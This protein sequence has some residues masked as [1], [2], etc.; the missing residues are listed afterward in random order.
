MPQYVIDTLKPKNNNNFP[1]AEAV[2]V[3]YEEGSTV[4]DKI[5]AINALIVA[6]QQLIE[7][8]QTDISELQSSKVDKVS[9]KDLSTNDFTNAYR[10]KIDD[11]YTKSETDTALAGKVD[12]VSGKGL[13]TNDFTNTYKNK[14]DNTYTKTETDSAI[15][16]KIAEVVAEAP[17]SFDTLKEIADWIDT[18][19]DSASAMNSAIQA[20]AANIEKKVDKVSGKDLSTNDFT[21]AYKDKIDDTYSKS[22]VDNKMK[23]KVDK[24]EG[25]DLSTNDF[26]NDYQ[27]RIHDTYT[28]AVTNA[29]AIEQLES[30]KADKSALDETN[31]AV[32]ANKENLQ[33]QID[34]LVLNAGGDSSPEVTQARVGLDGTSYETLKSRLDAEREAEQ[35]DWSVFKK[36]ISADKEIITH[37]FTTEGSKGFETSYK[38][39]KGVKYEIRVIESQNEELSAYIKDNIDDVVR[40]NRKAS[41][42][43]VPQHTGCLAVYDPGATVGSLV[44]VSIRPMIYDIAVE[45]VITQAKYADYTIDGYINN[46][47]TLSSETG[48]RTDYIPIKFGT[49]ISGYAR[50]LNGDLGI[51][52]FFDADKKP[53]SI[54]YGTNEYENYEAT[55]PENAA[56]VMFSK[57]ATFTETYAVVEWDAINYADKKTEMLE[58]V[59]SHTKAIKLWNFTIDGYVN[60][61][62][63]ISDETGKRT[64]YIPVKCGA[65]ITG[66]ARGLNGNLGIYGFFDADKNP[67]SAYYGTNDYEDYNVIVP[68]GVAYV[69]FSTFTAYTD[70]RAEIRWDALKYADKKVDELK[71]EVGI[72]RT[73]R[74][75]FGSDDGE[76]NF[77]NLYA[78]FEKAAKTNG[79]KT[80]H[81]NSGTYDLLS[82]MGGIEYISSKEN[83]KLSF[84]EVQPVMTDITIKGWGR[85]VIN[86]LLPERTVTDVPQLFSAINVKGNSHIENV[87]IHSCNCRY[88]IHDESG[89]KYPNTTS[90]YKNVKCYHNENGETLG[91]AQAIGCGYS[92]H[93]KVNLEDCYLLSNGEVWSCHANDG[94]EINFKNCVFKSLSSKDKALRISQNGQKNINAYIDSCYISNGLSLRNEWTE[95]SVTDVTNVVLI[96]TKINEVRNG[97][98]TVIEPVI[99]YNTVEGTETVL[100]APTD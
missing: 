71:D 63:G 54:F 91:Q 64:D 85:V 98:T 12:K 82:E 17:E 1:V 83:Q 35:E 23:D 14:V 87:E 92:D 9:G 10:D 4:K 100:L 74:V 34:N 65:V 57:I 50:G 76:H 5:I 60:N 26:T 29:S 68:S 22:E 72:E 81:I 47:G 32:A 20:N 43:F 28:K 96:N 99:S 41:A 42:T 27:K 69:V 49:K 21:T 56:Y 51:Y 93:Q 39:L 48:K 7:G 31:A 97:Y 45:K 15:A 38:L 18:H 67:V 24:V 3:L 77:S 61:L 78:C 2:D 25:K 33:G 11:T 70:T 58:E 75:G 62:G 66:Y 80:I 88:S 40:V 19:A 59:T 84:T 6:A 95:P 44:K 37:E 36:Y 46:L 90:S 52:G 30:I 53:I 55:A 94:V 8:V 86:F 73:F 13:S 89:N 79:K 16:G